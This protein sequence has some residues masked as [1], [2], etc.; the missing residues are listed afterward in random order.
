MSNATTYVLISRLRQQFINKIL[1]NVKILYEAQ[2]CIKNDENKLI[3]KM[4]F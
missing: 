2:S 1:A 4:G 3:K